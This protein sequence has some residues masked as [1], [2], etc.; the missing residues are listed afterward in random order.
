MSEPQKISQCNNTKTKLLQDELDD[1]VNEKIGKIRCAKE[2]LAHPK[3]Q[4]F[5]RLFKIRE[6]CLESYLVAST[7][8]AAIAESARSAA[9]TETAT[10]TAR[11]TGRATA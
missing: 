9:T 3:A 5:N 7:A 2:T 11:T 10:A 6:V 4:V 1:R 8:A